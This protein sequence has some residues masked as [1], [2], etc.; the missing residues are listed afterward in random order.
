MAINRL[1]LLTNISV[2]EVYLLVWA[3]TFPDKEVTLHPRCLV[4]YR[5]SV[6][7]DPSFPESRTP[8]RNKVIRAP[9]D[10]NTSIIRHL[11]QY[12]KYRNPG[13]KGVRNASLWAISSLIFTHVIPT[14]SHEGTRIREETEL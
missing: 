13:P 14:A 10:M 11:W 1:I 3:G 8:V 7:L 9:D 2:D 4:N 6:T 5:I 12:E